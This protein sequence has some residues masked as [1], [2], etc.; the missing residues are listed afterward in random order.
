MCV[1]QV[2]AAASATSPATLYVHGF[3][4]ILH[5]M[6]DSPQLQSSLQW[7]V[8]YQACLQL[9]GQALQCFAAEVLPVLMAHHVSGFG[10]STEQVRVCYPSTCMITC[11]NRIT[12]H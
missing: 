9:Q 3:T 4:E 11:Y 1:L 8:T 2:S 12:M 6:S 5:L 10:P 7:A